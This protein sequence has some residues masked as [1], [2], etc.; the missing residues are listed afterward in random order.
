MPL[1]PRPE[2][3]TT[4]ACHPS[5]D[6]LVA[7]V[8]PKRVHGAMPAALSDSARVLAARCARKR[9]S[10]T[11]II[12]L[13]LPSE[14]VS[15]AEMASDERTYIMVRRRR[16]AQ[17]VRALGVPRR[18]FSGTEQGCNGADQAG[19]RAARPGC[20]DHLPLREARLQ[21]RGCAPPRPR[22]RLRSAGGGRGRA[23]RRPVSEAAVAPRRAA[24]AAAASPR[25]A[26][27]RSGRSQRASARGSAS[28]RGRS[29]LD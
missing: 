12:P 8:H 21:A 20:G 24:I 23:G 13:F 26:E 28:D 7:A 9:R 10:Q 17:R 18:R 11:P 22:A 4:D 5:M 27:T 1:T 25:R 6:A 16:L 29:R 19:R 2:R 15:A 14:T 3:P